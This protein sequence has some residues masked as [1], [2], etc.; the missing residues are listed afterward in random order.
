VARPLSPVCDFLPIW[1][2]APL[3]K[4]VSS[5]TCSDNWVWSDTLKGGK[6]KISGNGKVINLMENGYEVAMVDIPMSEGRY[7]WKI[8]L[9]KIL[10]SVGGD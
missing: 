2:G 7:S 10:D 9:D 3:V 1:P 5:V 8:R 6:I 4:S